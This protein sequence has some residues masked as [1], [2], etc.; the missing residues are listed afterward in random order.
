MTDRKQGKQSIP[1]QSFMLITAVFS[2]FLVS[3]TP[4][5]A[6]KRSDKAIYAYS[7]IPY[8]NVGAFSATL[9][10]ACQKRLFSQKR[11]Y[12]YIISFIGNE[13]RAITGIASKDWNLYDP[14]GLAE[15]KMTYHFF[16]DG[17]SNC[18]VY[19]APQ[20]RN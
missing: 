3:L 8:K 12:R 16:N 17:F 4:A 14:T 1:K 10:R 5:E 20:P 13:G 15:D 11:Q 6:F 19:I 2:L 7:S 9:S 18:E